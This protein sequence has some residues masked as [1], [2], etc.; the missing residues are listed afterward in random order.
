M[1]ILL[2]G[3]GSIGKRHLGNLFHLGYRD[4]DV[5]TSKTSLPEPF[6]QLTFYKSV[7]NA[8]ANAA[9]ETAI[10][11]TPTSYHTPAILQLLKANIYR[12]YIEKPISHSLDDIDEVTSLAGSYLN[13]IV[14]GFD[15]HFEQGLQKVKA[16]LAENVIGNIV[17]INAQ[18]GQYLPDWRPAE[19]YRQGMSAKIAMGGGV[20]L[21]LVHEFDYVTCLAGPV[22]KVAALYNNS[23]T[24]EIETEDVA[25]VLLQFENGAVGTIHLDYL[26]PSLVR[27]C[28]ITGTEGSMQWN[29]ATNTVDWMNHKKESFTYDYKG[30]GRNDRFIEIMKCFL[31]DVPDTR[32]TNLTAGIKSLQLVL[33][34]K[35]SCDTQQFVKMNEMDLF[36]KRNPL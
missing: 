29:L 2:I 28:L 14:V 23:G 24:L 12:I 3:F 6:N 1:K 36:T 26:Q 10:L 11:C 18:V 8:L 22:K 13:K 30:F 34:A 7:E 21:D 4:I 25:E 16:L 33:A 27:N 31:A 19:D 9:Y 35:K 32:L 5:V 20:M 15:L 17:S